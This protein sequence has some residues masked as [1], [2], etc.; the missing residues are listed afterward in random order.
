MKKVISSLLILIGIV[1]ILSPFLTELIVKNIK[2]KTDP[3]KISLEELRENNK[4]TSQD[5]EFDFEAVEDVD[6]QAAI[7]GAL[8]YDKSQVQGILYIPDLDMTL[9]I[10][11]GLS[12]SNLLAGA[13]TM[14][15]GQSLGQGN[16]SLAGHNMKDPKLL[17]GSLMEIDDGSKVYTSDG[18]NIYEYQIYK[19]EVVPDDRIDMI[20][21]E[22]AKEK[23]IISLMTCYHTSKTG[24]RFFAVGE[25]IDVYPVDENQINIGS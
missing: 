8:N 25:L 24:K 3:S 1:L 11:K 4:D 13:G 22:K 10:M 16:F 20:S 5:T 7:K 23:P 9:P 6:I 21:D 17:F 19:R 14:K 18:E 2:N 12:H 15:E